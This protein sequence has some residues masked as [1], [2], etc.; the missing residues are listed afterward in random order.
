MT[1]IE[2]ERTN[3]GIRLYFVHET[4]SD[5]GCQEVQELTRDQMA[6]IVRRFRVALGSKND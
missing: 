5:D 3:T 1:R 2:F 4:N 6:E